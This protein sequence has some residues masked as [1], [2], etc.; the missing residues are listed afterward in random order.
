MSDFTPDIT[1]AS[2]DE[3]NSIDRSLLE[4]ISE[5][6]GVESAFGMMLAIDYPVEI[7]GN[8]GRLTCFLMGILCWTASKSQ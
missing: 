3:S 6:S 4:D 5:I 7:N 8:A 2:E 1:I